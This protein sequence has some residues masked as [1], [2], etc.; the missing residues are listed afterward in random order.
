MRIVID[1][2]GAQTRSRFRGIGRYSTAIAQAIAQNSNGHE[3]WLVL[4]GRLRDAISAVRAVFEGLIP[5]ERIVVFDVPPLVSSESPTNLWRRRASELIRESF[6]EELQPDVVYITSLFEGAYLCDAVLS[7]GTLSSHVP[8]A[9]ILYDLIPLLDQENYLPSIWVRQWYM[10]KVENLMRADLLFSISEHSRQEAIGAL[11]IEGERIV[12]ISTAHTDNFRLYPHDEVAYQSL[13][14][15]YNINM[16]FIMYNGALESRKNLD[17]LL[18]AFSLLPPELRLC[19]QLIFVGKVAKVDHQRLMHLAQKIGI[20]E[21]FVLTG[22]VPDED[23]VALFSHCTL[24]VFPSLHEGFGLP[25][26]EAMACGAPTIGSNVTSIPEVIGR[27]DALFDPKNPEDIAAKIIKA[28]TDRDFRQSLRQHALVQATKFSWDICAK[29]AIAALEQLYES[30][31]PSQPSQSSDWTEIADKRD[32]GYRRL[33][34]AIAAIPREPVGPSEEDLILCANC[35]AANQTITERVA[36]ANKLPE[37]Q[38]TWRVEGPFDSSYSLAL[39]NRETAL[40]LDDLGHHV[41]LHST[42][43]PGDFLPNAKFLRVN[44]VIAALHARSL[45]I[46][47]ANAEVT[48]RNLYPPRVA[49][50]DC[51]C[52]LLHH[53]AWEESGFPREWVEDFNDHLQGMT[54]LSRHVE[55]IM[56]DHGVTVPMSVSGCGVDHWERIEPDKDIT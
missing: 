45:E 24:F 8:T 29:R 33:I 41:V 43:G 5:T 7:I 4:N 46:S 54:C 27:A 38:I 48:S 34:K 37:Q 51:R 6:I 50:M 25:A 21:Q 22:H 42:E 36:R 1:M 20:H 52:N 14:S 32:Q 18:V 47:S 12:T 17:R 26:L 15:R 16:P 11:E 49:D 23:L 39:L 13:S 56:I 35:I 10:D 3:V 53:Y 40:A 55:K 44:P 31:H 30:N 9:V 28:L 2:Q 19:H